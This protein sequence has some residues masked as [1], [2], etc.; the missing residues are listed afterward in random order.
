VNVWRERLALPLYLSA[1]AIATAGWLW[2]LFAGLE[3][4]I[5]I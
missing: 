5:G 1:V 3:W 4:A 2:M